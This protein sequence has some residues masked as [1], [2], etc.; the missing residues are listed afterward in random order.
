[1]EKP[2]ALE[3]DSVVLKLISDGE[4]YSPWNDQDLCKVLRIKEEFQVY[5]V[6]RDAIK[7]I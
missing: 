1:M 7:T 4:R 3:N 6:Y 5:C 2:P